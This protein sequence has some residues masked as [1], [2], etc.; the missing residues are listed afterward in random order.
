MQPKTKKE[1]KPVMSDTAN[2]NTE[3]R[4]PRRLFD[5]GRIV[6]TP[7][8]LAACAPDYMRECLARHVG[9]DWAL[10]VPTT[11]RAI[12]MR[13]FRADVSFRPIRLTL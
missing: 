10:S 12:S 6:A 8:V 11:A 1:R 2:D 5:R 9:G 3:F 4:V 7:G 13:C